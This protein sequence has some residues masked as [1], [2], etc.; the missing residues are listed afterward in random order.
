MKCTLCEREIPE[1]YR[2]KHH[3]TPRAK[4][5]DETIIVC[6]DCG[7]QIHMLFTN[8]ELRDLYNTVE[9]LKAH[10]AMRKWIKWVQ[11]KSFGIRMRESKRM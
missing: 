4:G 2:G 8:N 7:N 10:P 6:T 1:E 3:L 5:G 11:K 9:S